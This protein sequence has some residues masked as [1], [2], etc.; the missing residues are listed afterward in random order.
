[1]FI[2]LR[3]TSMVVELTP[4]NKTKQNKTKQKTKTKTNKQMALIILTCKSL[5]F[6]LLKRF[7]FLIEVML[8]LAN[9][10]HIVYIYTKVYT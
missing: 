10:V 4:K 5:T 7:S 9:L 2:A 3:S 6:F 8:Q 1:M